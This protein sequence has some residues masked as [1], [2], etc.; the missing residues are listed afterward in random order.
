MASSSPLDIVHALCMSLTAGDM[1]HA[2]PYLAD[3]VHYHNMPW[4]PVH[5]AQTVADF[6]QPFVDGTQC[7]LKE[8]RIL[9]AVGN[10]NVVM[11]AREETWERRGLRVMLPVA[12]VFEVKDGRIVRWCDY[13]DLATFKPMLDAISAD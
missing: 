8:M 10:G 9:H 13:W 11:N 12:G 1:R 4:T 6:L 3:E 7:M 2:L 5:G